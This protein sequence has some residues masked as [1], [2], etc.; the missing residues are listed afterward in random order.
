MSKKTIVE[1]LKNLDADLELVVRNIENSDYMRLEGTLNCRY[2]EGT[3][4]FYRRVGDKQTY[5]SS[6]HGPE[7]R[8]LCRKQYYMTMLA[9]AKRERFQISRC[10]TIL[11]SKKG[12]SDV[13]DVISTLS[14]P[15]RQIIEP[16]GITDDGY[17]KLWLKEMRKGRNRNHEINSPLKAPDG[18]TMKSKSEIIIANRLHAFGVP[19]VYEERVTFDDG[20]HFIYPDFIVLNKR[21][22]KQF[23]WEH[24]GKI[25]DEDYVDKQQIKLEQYAR[26]NIFPGD[27]LLVSFESRERSL[28]TEYVDSV[29][30]KYLL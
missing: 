17:A 11:E 1:D 14:I 18:T 12:L 25:S 13:D 24:F 21:T 7:I 28:S 27:G 2:E 8:N 3:T 30:K 26:N 20:D 10:L 22:R 9:A 23:Y 19:F 4:R 5:L 29:I 16:M 6:D 15:V